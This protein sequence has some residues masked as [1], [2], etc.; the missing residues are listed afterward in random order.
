MANPKKDMLP[1]RN[2]K[3]AK[4]PEA[5]EDAVRVLNEALEADPVAINA[6][7]NCSVTCNSKLANHPTIQVGKEGD[8]VWYVRLLGIINGLFGVDVEQWGFIYMS[9]SPYGTIE[10][11]DFFKK[12]DDNDK[13]E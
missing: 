2:Y 8:S 7:F 9:L 5:I 10:K 12:E 1:A 13:A 3:D 6:L 4:H 11:F